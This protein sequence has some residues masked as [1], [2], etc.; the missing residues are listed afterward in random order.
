VSN[1][2]MPDTDVNHMT[3][4]K[5]H[6]MKTGRWCITMW[7]TDGRTTET[8]DSLV[9]GMPNDWHLEG[10]IEQGVDSQEKLHAQLFLK[11]PQCRGSRIAKFFPNCYIDEARNP[12][13]LKNYVHKQDTRVAEF[14][15]I[16]NRSPQWSV[17]CDKFF[18]WLVANKPSAVYEKQDDDRLKLWDQFIGISI[19]EGMRVDVIGVNPQ[20]RSCIMRYWDAYWHCADQRTMSKNDPPSIDEKTDRQK[21]EPVAPPPLLRK[22]QSALIS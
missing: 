1:S 22:C 20:Y 17:V 19:M 4:K 10:Q 14:K 9:Q 8:L 2:T 7:L 15:T 3:T 6:E 11:T 12:F 21:D 13:A 18:D 5:P 16:E